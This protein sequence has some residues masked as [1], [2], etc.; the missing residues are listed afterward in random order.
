MFFG[1]AVAGAAKSRS[2]TLPL[3]W[4]ADERRYHHGTMKLGLRH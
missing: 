1:K 4:F 3:Y 2:V